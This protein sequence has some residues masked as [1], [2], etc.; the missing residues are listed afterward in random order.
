MATEELGLE[1]SECGKIVFSI[2]EARVHEAQFSTEDEPH[3]GWDTVS[4]A[5]VDGRD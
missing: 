5:E 1:C 2:Y 3:G 4:K